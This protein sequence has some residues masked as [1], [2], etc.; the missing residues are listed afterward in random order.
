M[1]SRFLFRPRTRDS[2]PAGSLPQPDFEASV[3]K[4][5]LGTGSA[6]G[7]AGNTRSQFTHQR[8][9]TVAF[10]FKTT[11]SSQEKHVFIDEQYCSCKSL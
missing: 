4:V 1:T 2:F 7:A 8:K 11:V 10:L 3:D 6:I 9:L 5:I